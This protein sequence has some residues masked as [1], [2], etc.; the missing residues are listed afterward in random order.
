[1][2]IYAL[3][4]L[5]NALA[6]FMGAEAELGGKAVSR[7]WADDVSPEK[8]AAWCNSG[9]DLVKQDTETAT[10]ETCAVEYSRLMHKCLA[11]RRLEHLM[12][13]RALCACSLMAEH[14][15]DFHGMF[16]RLTFFKPSMVSD[17][18]QLDAFIAG[19]L[20]LTSE[21]DGTDPE[22]AAVDWRAWLER[23][24]A[25]VVSE[26]GNGRAQAIW[27]GRGR[28]RYHTLLILVC[29]LRT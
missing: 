6:P 5:L 14:A 20:V 4:A 21:P 1:M 22:K 16:R 11:V 10:V 19:V 28:R 12:T 7:G 9:L 13:R 18:P 25:H 23:Y 8:L 24:A 17:A 2:I 3:W 26:R 15:L 27:T 29:N